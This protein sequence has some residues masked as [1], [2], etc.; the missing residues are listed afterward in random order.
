M[1][2]EMSAPLVSVIMNCLNG[3]RDGGRDLRAALD[4]LMA[5]TLTD[6]ELVFWDNGSTDQTPDIVR[7]YVEQDKGRLRYFRGAATVPLGAARNL[8]LAEARGR[9]LAF[10]DC[11]DLWRPQKLE[12]Q[13][14]LF[15]SNPRVGLV[16]TDT[17]I[18]DKRRV[19]KRLFVEAA[20]ARGMAFAQLMERQWISMSSAMIRREALAALAADGCPPGAG[21][22]GG[23]FDESL[24]VCEEADV[25][26]RI[27]HDW[28]L[29]YVDE[30]LTLWRVH[31]ANTTF[32]KFGQFAD[33]TLR[34]LDKHCRL[35][36]GYAQEH[37]DL[38]TLLSRR[39]AFQ[40]AVA[41]WRQGQNAQA[42]EAVRPW[43]HDGRK[44]RLFWWASY[45]PGALFDLAARLYFA[46][47]A[48]LRR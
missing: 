37:A 5:Q 24:N 18:F 12:K 1:S 2:R 47:P 23:W 21:R 27:A 38:V 7:G 42:R 13:A 16:C 29:D 22:N 26:Y 9:Y 45:L 6:F 4:S 36:P 8:A 11:D 19:L 48:G 35:Y 15:E 10:L 43:R 32:R 41:L 30:P 17:E 20:P 25:F 14:A 39:A 28:E 46:L 40:K 3:A 33:E 31:G 34:I 44:Y